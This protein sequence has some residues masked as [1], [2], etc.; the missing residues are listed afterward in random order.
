LQ[1]EQSAA[2]LYEAVLKYVSDGVVPFHVPGHKQG[3][4]LPEMASLSGQ[5]LLGMDVNGMKDLDFIGNPSGVIREA[6]MLMARAFHARRAYFLVNGTT[7]GVQA[8]IMAA[9]EPGSE[10]IIPRNA[11]KS[12]FG[13]IILSGAMPVYVQPQCDRR[14]GIATG[15]SLSDMEMVIKAHPHARAVLVIN[16]SYYGIAAD[17]KAIV[18]LAHSYDMAVL[19]DEAHGAHLYFH[20]GFPVTAMEAGADMSAASM[21]KTSGS[22]T[23]S[24][25]LLYRSKMIAVERV[26]HVL[27][28]TYTSS[29]SYLLM[30]SLDLARKQMALQG[31]KLL[32][33]T[34]Q[35]ARGARDSINRI[36]E[37]YAFGPEMLGKPGCYG[38]D[39]TKLGIHVA[40]LGISGYQVED[41]LRKRFNIQV[42][43]SDLHNILAIVTIGDNELQVRQLV[44]ALT[45]LA[46]EAKHKNSPF[47]FEI[48]PPPEMIVSPRD[49]FYSPTK[50]VS[51]QAADGEI[52]AEMLMAYPPGIPVVLPGERITANMIDYIELLKQQGCA[53]QGTADPKVN[54]I[55]ILGSQ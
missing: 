33:Q 46:S 12:T 8:M 48:P 13:G 1:K 19:V 35:L 3:R 40:A 53:L 16:P 17:L 26:K 39:E 54:C 42:E 32:S 31:R 51:L 55:R 52:A 49:A 10:I 2:P 36:A 47:Y 15:V 11:H 9:C 6:Q 41:T 4:G 23:Q 18:N 25:V 50:S 38:F 44:E 5:Q 34:L 22:L 27:D 7:S 20:P 43:M 30:A 28:L 24:S 14:L 37:L 45:Q 21:H 29:A